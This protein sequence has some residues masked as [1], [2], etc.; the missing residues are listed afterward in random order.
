MHGLAVS[1]KNSHNVYG[2]DACNYSRHSSDNRNYSVYP[3]VG[4]NRKNLGCSGVAKMVNSSH[5]S[6]KEKEFKPV[7]ASRSETGLNE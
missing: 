7:F 2:K 4:R 5:K 3:V 6:K 1:S